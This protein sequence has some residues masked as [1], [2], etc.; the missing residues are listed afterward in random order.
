MI[1][2]A[3]TADKTFIVRKTFFFMLALKFLK[4]KN[5]IRNS[6]NVTPPQIARDDTATHVLGMWLLHVI[7]KVY[8]SHPTVSFYCV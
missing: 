4:K 8:S 3:D 5:K 7:R 2:H 6:K 1:I